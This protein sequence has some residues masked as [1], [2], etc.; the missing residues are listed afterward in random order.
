[1]PSRLEI[2]C[3]IENLKK[4]GISEDLIQLIMAEKYPDHFNKDD[5][6]N[7]MQSENEFIYNEMTKKGFQPFHEILSGNIIEDGQPETQEKAES[8]EGESQDTNPE[9]EPEG[10]PSDE[11]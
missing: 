5:I 4:H 1:M 10:H 7:E 6:I 2:N 8:Q 3:E 11:H 9:A